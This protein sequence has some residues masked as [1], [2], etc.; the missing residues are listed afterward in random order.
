MTKSVIV[1]S[2]HVAR[3]SVGNRAA[4]FALE[5]LGHPVWAIPTIILPFHPGHGLATRIVPEIGQFRSLLDDLLNSRWIDEVSAVLTGYMANGEQA[6]IV[7]EF[8]NRI[9]S[10]R[11]GVMHVCDPVLG[12]NDRLYVTEDTVS[13]VKQHLC[14]DAD[15][16]TPNLFELGWITDTNPQTADQAAAA[17]RK[18]AGKAVLV[19]SVPGF[20]RGN[21]GNLLVENGKAIFAEHRKMA[22]TPNGPGDLTA[23]LFLSNRIAGLD[24]EKTLRRTTASV[25]EIVASAAKRNADELMLETDSKSIVSP[26]ATIQLRQLVIPGAKGDISQ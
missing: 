15:V 11:P 1:I 4:V 26:M 10:A 19:T 7:G 25:F 22:N 23:A 20:M 13:A 24:Q 16:I 21:I 5:V 17:A 14:A 3:G 2:S 6:E 8:I 12:D 9:K 18:I